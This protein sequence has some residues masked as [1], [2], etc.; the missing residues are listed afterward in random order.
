MKRMLFSILLVACSKSSPKPAAPEPAP[1]PAPADP[2]PVS[3]P[4]PAPTPT[5]PP[6]PAPPPPPKEAKVELAPTAKSK[7]KVKGTITFKEVEG[8][9]EVTANVEGL[10]ANKEHA[11]HIH[12]TGDCSAPDATSAG[13]HF[14]PGG[15]PHGAPD[16]EH[17]HEGDFGNLKAD[18]QGKATK[19]FVMKGITIAEG[20]TS[21][22]G[23]GF[24]VHAKKDDLKSQPSGNAGDRIACGVIAVSQ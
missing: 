19:T 18:K 16:A 10:S 12:E 23:K 2:A 20:A 14:N 7:S 4:E 9:V 15:H 5:P 8:G 6:E 11:W 24:I 13:E 1:E 21:I 3:T 22:V 17:R